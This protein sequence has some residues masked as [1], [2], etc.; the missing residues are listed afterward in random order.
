MSVKILLTWNIKTNAEQEY[1]GFMVGSFL[2][3]VSHKEISLTDA[4]VTLYGNGPRIMVGMVMPDLGAAHE[5]LNS[6]EWQNLHDQ[7]L[8]FVE[9]YNCKIINQKGAFQL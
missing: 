5:L 4:W 6:E 1:Y 2:P 8:E 7:L 3:W 9:D